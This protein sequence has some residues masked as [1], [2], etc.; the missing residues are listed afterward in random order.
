M[1]GGTHETSA[2]LLADRYIAG[3]S[4]VRIQIARECEEQGILAALVAMRL[5]E[6]GL[7]KEFVG[8]MKKSL[9]TGWE[10]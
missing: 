5:R 9:T 7:D 1:V 4:A 3:D 10:R 2:E 6:S 8:A